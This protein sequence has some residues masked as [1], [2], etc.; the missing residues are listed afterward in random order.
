MLHRPQ[1]RIGL[2]IF[3]NKFT[4]RAPS[5]LI[6]SLACFAAFK[7][8]SST[9]AANSAA[10]SRPGREEQPPGSSP[11]GRVKHSIP[12]GTH[13]S[14]DFPA[15]TGK[16]GIR[17]HPESKKKTGVK[18]RT[19]SSKRQRHSCIS[20]QPVSKLVVSPKGNLD[21]QGAHCSGR[22]GL[23]T[24]PD[25]LTSKSMRWTLNHSNGV[26]DGGMVE[27]PSSERAAPST[28]TG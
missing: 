24:L 8:P 20:Q 28:G 18:N 4:S 3:H 10:P 1:G 6:F 13:S 2:L 22:V 7:I 17:S 14:A 19:C 16:F 21:S 5:V 26:M 27:Q 23:G 15:T 9:A 12:D 25:L 11:W